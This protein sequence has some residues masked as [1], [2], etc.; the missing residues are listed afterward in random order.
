MGRG[1]YL[2]PIFFT[3][4]KKLLH[5][6]NRMFR[7]NLIWSHGKIILAVLAGALLFSFLFFQPLLYVLIPVV[8]FMLYFFRNPERECV[9]AHAD[10]SI[11]VSP[12]D[13]TV[14]EIERLH[15]SE[16]ACKIAIFMSPLDVHV[17]RI[18]YAGTIVNMSYRPGKFYPA[19]VPKSSDLNEAH[20]IV[21]ETKEG[22]RYRVR[23][24]AGMLARRIVCWVA[25]GEICGTGQAFGMIKLSSRV[26]LFVP[27]NVEVAVRMGQQVYA[28]HT[29]VGHWVR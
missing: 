13:G 23:Q 10:N 14:V 11:I 26:D 3:L 25:T 29:I 21:V 24:I 9:Q 18:P 8:V 2:L 19:Y 4:I 15:D 5:R 20:D 28:G 27:K 1:L 12:A 16:Y 22:D 6:K 17:N 7:N